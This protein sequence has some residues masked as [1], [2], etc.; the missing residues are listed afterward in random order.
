M[1]E[2]RLNV[3]KRRGNQFTTGNRHKIQRADIG[4]RGGPAVA[5]P[6]DFAKTT[7]GEIAH[8]GVAEPPG[9][10]DPETIATAL[11][12]RAEQDEIPRRHPPSVFLDGGELRPRPQANAG[13]ERQSH[14]MGRTAR[15]AVRGRTL[16]W[17]GTLAG[18]DGQALPSLGATTLQHETAVLRVHPDQETMGSDTAAAIRLIR[19]L[20]WT[21]RTRLLTP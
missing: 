3:G 11:I 19:T 9:C 15:R 18:R 2:L 8:D 1:L 16:L 5:V 17:P 13:F 6:E 12:R 10:D 7:F 14:L 4:W 21:P 20:H